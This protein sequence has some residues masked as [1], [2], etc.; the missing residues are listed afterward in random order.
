MITFLF[1]VVASAFFAAT[2]NA[3]KKSIL[4]SSLIAALGY[5]LYIYMAAAGSPVAGYFFATVLMASLCE[6]FARI[7]KM[8]AVVLI[9][10]AVIP[11]VPG[12]GLYEMVLY[13]VLGD[14]ERALH[15]GISAMMAIGAMAMGIAL[16]T[17]FA[18]LILPRA[19][20]YRTKKVK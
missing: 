17:F 5:S 9:T 8:P 4:I 20:K 10:P 11:V 12:L 15:T 6:V 19:M 1:C 18:R 7:I 14:F 3:P 2:L 13:M 16:S